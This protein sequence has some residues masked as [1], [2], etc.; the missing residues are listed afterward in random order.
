MGLQDNNYID[1]L[2]DQVSPALND[3]RVFSEVAHGIKFNHIVPHD[4]NRAMDGIDLRNQYAISTQED[5]VLDGSGCTFLEMLIGLAIRMNDQAWDW[6]QP[7]KIPY[8]CSVLIINAGLT[9]FFDKIMD[10][11]SEEELKRRLMTINRRQYSSNGSG[12]FFPLSRPDSDQRG[13]EL[14]YQLMSWLD[15]NL[16]VDA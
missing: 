4:D 15:E 2:R 7:D 12:G 13:V 16:P 1:W 14:W 3:Y 8:W 9:E 11:L 10:P 5:H 6:K